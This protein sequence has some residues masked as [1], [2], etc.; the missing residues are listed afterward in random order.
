MRKTVVLNVVGLPPGLLSEATPRP[1]DAS[2]LAEVRLIVE[3]TDGV[4]GVHSRAPEAVRSRHASCSGNRL[5]A[6]CKAPLRV[7][8][9]VTYSGA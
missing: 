4:A 9:T 5:D 1:N 8:R 6:P 2:R 7:R 3:A